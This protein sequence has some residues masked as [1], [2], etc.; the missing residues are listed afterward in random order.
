MYDTTDND[1]LK[2]ILRLLDIISCKRGRRLHRAQK[3]S[4]VLLERRSSPYNGSSYI[5]PNTVKSLRHYFDMEEITI[6]E[7]EENNDENNENGTVTTVNKQKRFFARIHPKVVNTDD[8]TTAAITDRALIERVI[9]RALLPIVRTAI[10]SAVS[11]VRRPIHTS[12]WIPKNSA[13]YEEED[14]ENH[15]STDNESNFNFSS[16]RHWWRRVVGR[17]RERS[18][19]END[20]NAIAAKLGVVRRCRSWFRR[21]RPD[22]DN[23]GSS[24]TTVADFGIWWL[25]SRYY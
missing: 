8:C 16:I 7:K 14:K 23:G 24:T 1:S 6:A 3:Q 25:Y 18:D 11:T 13:P 5:N 21:R 9:T 19:N 22:R 2:Y 10:I 20:N 17:A 4:I 12:S 15:R